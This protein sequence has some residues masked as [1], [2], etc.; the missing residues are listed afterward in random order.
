MDEPPEHDPTPGILDQLHR[1]RERLQ[2]EP[3]WKEPTPDQLEDGRRAFDEAIER[4]R[5]SWRRG[6]RWERYATHLARAAVTTPHFA[7]QTERPARAAPF[8]AFRV[9]SDNAKGDVE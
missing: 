7:L 5:P 4:V 2:A 8:A 6:S 9:G 3:G 1:I